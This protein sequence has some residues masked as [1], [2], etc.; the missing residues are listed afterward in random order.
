MEKTIER[1]VDRKEEKERDIGTERN[2]EKK[3]QN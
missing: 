1:N 3:E 2:L